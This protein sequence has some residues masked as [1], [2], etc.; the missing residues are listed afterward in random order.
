V[1]I[2]ISRFLFAFVLAV[3]PFTANAWGGTFSVFGPRVYVRASGEP[4]AV[5]N[6]FTVHNPGNQYTLHVTNGGLQDDDYDF[7]SS[8]T[9]R[10]NGVVVVAPRD[11]NHD[12]TTLDRPVNL[13]ATNTISVELHGKPGGQLAVQIFGVDNDPPLIQAFISPQPNAAG[14]NNSDVTVSYTCSDALSGVAICPG[15]QVVTTE[16]IIQTVSGP[17]TDIAGN[18]TSATVTIK[19]DKTPPTV[20]R[21]RSPLPISVFGWNNTDVTVTFICTDSGSGIAS[22]PP[23]VTVTKEGANQLVSGIATDVAGNSAPI[24]DSVS[25]DKTPPVLSIATPAN[26]ST[27]STAALN[28]FGRLSDP[29]SG[30]AGITCNGQP[31]IFTPNPFAPS[32]LCSLTLA[33]GLNTI[34]VVVTDNAGNTT[35][36]LVS[37]T[38]IA[39]SSDTD[40]DGLTDAVEAAIGTNPLQ[41]STAADGIADG[42]KVF[43]GFDPFSPI[44]AQDADGDGLTNLQ[45]FLAGSDPRKSD[46]TAPAVAQI[47][48]ADQSTDFPLNGRII[49]RFNEPLLGGVSPAAAQA[50]I[51]RVA[52]SLATDFQAAAAKVLQD[53]LQRTCCANSIVPGVLTVT[54]GTT[55][56]AGSAVLSNDGLSLTF[57]PSGPLAANT[58][59]SVQANGVRDS[60]GNLMTQAFN[61]T[62]TT[63][64]NTDTIA[65]SIVQTS[66]EL[67][68]TNV[69]TNAAFNLQFSKRMDPAT[70]TTQSI[71]MQDQALPLN[72]PNTPH[73]PGS[74]QV[75]PDGLT[76]AF[77]PDAPLPIN[78]R[79]LVLMNSGLIR[80]ASGNSLPL[81]FF[82]FTVGAAPDVDLPHLA[83]SGPAGGDTGIP[84][85]ALVTLQFNEPLN[86]ITGGAGIQVSAGGQ[87]VPG[88]IAFS[89]ANRRLTFTPASPLTANTLY[90]VTLAPTISD[91]GGNLID[92]PGS[93]SFQTGATPD[94]TPL[95]LVQVTPSAGT[96]GVP[97]NTVIQAQF[98][99][100]ILPLSIQPTGILVTPVATGVP[101]AGSISVSPDGLLATFTPSA[102]LAAGTTY[103]VRLIFSISDLEGNLLGFST[104]SFTT[105]P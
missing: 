1:R 61:S 66:P 78:R 100:G 50:A 79:F 26:G 52:P 71:V 67:G 33:T 42:W 38:F 45:E 20:S 39:P 87:P 55:P 4:V 95:T 63:G 89:V 17:A 49:V 75:D 2:S 76:A 60:A 51:A 102:P 36:A 10:I 101:I 41:A 92:N 46:Q 35:T 27:V 32:L 91:L 88:S 14:W 25:I 7:V 19:L 93:F 31:G 48:P 94:T 43:Y 57:T 18:T 96:T 85:N 34:P 11:L 62:L 8:G 82:I 64:S 105:A 6:T 70:L 59:Y 77:I 98:S 53:Y 104:R 68:L 29:L 80:D 47:F 23:P 16:G 28:I 54:Q 83:A 21:V 5:S 24:G 22:C 73:I 9:I 90:T 37:V 12:T 13:L 84:T 40:N 69:P 3:L 65:P 86:I 81:T 97:V 15:P 56:V 72:S 103:T 44:A 58:V 30:F 99:K 74:I